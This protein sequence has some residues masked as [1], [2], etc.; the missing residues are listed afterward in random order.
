MS[1]GIGNKMSQNNCNR[2]SEW[3]P[4]R[5]FVVVFFPKEIG[6]QIVKLIIVHLHIVVVAYFTKLKR[7][8]FLD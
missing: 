4:R 3:A 8:F 2:S 5:A 1:S 6:Q 7:A